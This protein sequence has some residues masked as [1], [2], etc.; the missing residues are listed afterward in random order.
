M[1]NIGY[2]LARM[3]GQI[4]RNIYTKLIQRISS[5][6]I[7]QSRKIDITIYSF[8]CERDLPEQVASIRSFIRNIGIPERFVVISDGSYS[9]SSCKLL[10]RIHPCVDVI[11]FTKLLRPD[12]P[13]CVTN[14]IQIHPMG[15]KLATLMSISVKG[16]T[17]YTDSDILFFP[18]GVDLINLIKVHETSCYYLPDCSAS[19]DE[20]LIYDECE[21][22]Q[23]V[24]AGFLLFQHELDWNFAIE[25]LDKLQD[26]PIYFTEQTTVHLTIHHNHGKPFC[27][28]KYI[29]N[30]EDQFVYPDKFASSE[31]AIRHYVNDV[32]HK[33]WMNIGL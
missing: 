7:N 25:R 23:P 14:Y 8:S 28:E 31:I 20:R 29:L 18:G 2:H 19:L 21:K 33:F 32:R 27:P 9:D 13:Q 22:S 3:Q 12:L 4:T 26:N 17:I 5:Y 10:R 24:N 30:V 16:A 15:K 1:V 11:P 6:S